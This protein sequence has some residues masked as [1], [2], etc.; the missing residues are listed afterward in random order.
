MLPNAA[1]NIQKLQE[2]VDGSAGKITALVRA[3]SAE[4][5][6]ALSGLV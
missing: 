6:T 1:E 2:L 5:C 3:L 4:P